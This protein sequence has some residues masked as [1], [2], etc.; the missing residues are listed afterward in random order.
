MRVGRLA[1]AQEQLGGG[2]L[3]FGAGALL[4]RQ[5]VWNHVHVFIVGHSLGLDITTVFPVVYTQVQEG[6]RHFK[7]WDALIGRIIL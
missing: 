2:W 5:S 3:G 4:A 1:K 6:V 7:I